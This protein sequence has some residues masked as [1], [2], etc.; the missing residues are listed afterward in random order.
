[1]NLPQASCQFLDSSSSVPPPPNLNSCKHPS[2]S[3]F[4][5]KRSP[6]FCVLIIGIGSISCKRIAFNCSCSRSIRRRRAGSSR[7]LYLL[8]EACWISGGGECHT[9]RKSSLDSRDNRF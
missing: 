8:L 3:L 1:L 4:G 5:C 9:D 7:Q 2:S 6:A